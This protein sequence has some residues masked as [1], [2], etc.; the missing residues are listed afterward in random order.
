MRIA[1]DGPAGSGKSTIAK[2]ISR[3]LNIPYL[4]TGLA[5]RATAYLA[6]KYIGDPKDINWE[7]LKPCL[8]RLEIIPK[9][10]ETI[11]KVDGKRLEEELRDEEVGRAASII[12]TIPEF[13]EYIN[14][15]FRRLIGG[16]QAVVEGRD[17]GTNIIPDADLKIFITASPEERARRRYLQLRSS[18]EEVDYEEILRRIVE[19]DRRDMERERY[20]FKPASDAVI[21]DTTDRKP[22]EV[23]LEVFTLIDKVKRG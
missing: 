21:I 13:R 5:Y 15:V 17:A 20:P 23:L 11:V 19:R 18:K 9:V 2:E 3:R 14:S 7:K 10:G 22:E 16:D 12:G 4:E 6:L 8:D 1:V